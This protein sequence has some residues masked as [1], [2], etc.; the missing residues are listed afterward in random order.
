M[1]VACRVNF[2]AVCETGFDQDF[3]GYY[4]KVIKKRCEYCQG[5]FDTKAGL[6][7][8]VG[9]QKCYYLRKGIQE[10]PNTILPCEEHAC[11]KVFQSLKDL[12]W[13]MM[14]HWGGEFECKD[15]SYKSPIEQR[16]IRHCQDN[17]GG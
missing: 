8:H 1:Q 15:C 9:V 7:V 17:H 6:Y 4:R 10:E 13:H 11:D 2:A 16:M 12:K 5:D 3:G 14:E